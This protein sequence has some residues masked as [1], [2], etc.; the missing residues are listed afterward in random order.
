VVEEPDL[1]GESVARAVADVLEE[2]GRLRAM[3]AASRRLGRPDAAGRVA[4][5]VEGRG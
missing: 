5:L 4:D 2:P 1:R 3:E